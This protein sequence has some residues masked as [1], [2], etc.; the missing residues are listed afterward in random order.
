MHILCL[1][2]K[3]VL[4]KHLRRRIGNAF[5]L[6]IVSEDPGAI[7]RRDTV[8]DIGPSSNSSS[9]S[10]SP[11]GAV[12]HTLNSFLLPTPFFFRRKDRRN[13]ATHVSAA[14]PFSA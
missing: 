4:Q 6:L 7:G 1:L 14:S 11:L 12:P 10:T 8:G 9:T 2:V 3:H 5:T 13:A